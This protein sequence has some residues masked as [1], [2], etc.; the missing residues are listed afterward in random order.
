MALL[1]R[2]SERVAAAVLTRNDG[3]HTFGKATLR[4]MFA[5]LLWGAVIG[6][7]GA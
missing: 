7:G 1:S 4:G 6:E 3:S 2:G 5:R